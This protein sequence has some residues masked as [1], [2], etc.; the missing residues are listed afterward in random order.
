MTV[1]TT[2]RWNGVGVVG[3]MDPTGFVCPA[4]DLCHTHCHRQGNDTEKQKNRIFSL[5]DHPSCWLWKARQPLL[6]TLVEVVNVAAAQQGAIALLTDSN[7]FPDNRPEAR[8]KILWLGH[9]LRASRMSGAR[10]ILHLYALTPPGQQGIIAIS[11][12]GLGGGSPPAA[13]GADRAQGVH[14]LAGDGTVWF[15]LVFWR[16]VSWETWRTPSDRLL[17]RRGTKD[18]MAPQGSAFKNFHGCCT[19]FPRRWDY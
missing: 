16:P 7:T 5:L 3:E 10:V 8:Q 19:S 4:V 12:R 13:P 11:P 1:W 2:I 18:T 15:W 9:G 6:H 17:A 14:A